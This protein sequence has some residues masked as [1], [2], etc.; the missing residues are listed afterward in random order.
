MCAYHQPFQIT[1]D[2][3]NT[4]CSL[5]WHDTPHHQEVF[6]VYPPQVSKYLNLKGFAM[7]EI[8]PHKKN[9]PSASAANISIDYPQPGAII[10]LPRDLD[11]R[12]QKL[13]PQ[14]SGFHPETKIFWYLDDEFLGVTSGRENLPLLPDSGIHT[15]SLIDESGYTVSTSFEIIL[16]Q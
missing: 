12:Q 1:N 15:L 3:K 2:G 9:C 5:C 16:P 11:L 13:T 8:P 10:F 7:Q 4:V 14:L 6:L